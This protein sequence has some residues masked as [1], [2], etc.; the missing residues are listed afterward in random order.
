MITRRELIM[1]LTAIA[2]AAVSGGAQVSG[3]NYQARFWHKSGD[4]VYCELCP[5]GCVLP[6]GKTGICRNRKN[7]KGL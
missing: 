5:H 4:A 2:G 1:S 7:V 3:K 6:E